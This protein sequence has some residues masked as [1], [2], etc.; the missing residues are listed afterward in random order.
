MVRNPNLPPKG[1][2]SGLFAGAPT[3]S[4][5]WTPVAESTFRSELVN[6]AQTPRAQYA[7]LP[8]ISGHRGFSLNLRSS[9]E[10]VEYIRLTLQLL[11]QSPR[12]A[13]DN[14]AAAEFKNIFERYIAE[15][16]RETI[17][18]PVGSSWLRLLT[19]AVFPVRN[20]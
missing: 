2:L 10:L 13:L 8:K 11:E 19:R 6:I 20:Q 4:T 1:I 9:R 18:R 5:S 7:N 15:L 12:G 3:S 16:E 17:S 14:R